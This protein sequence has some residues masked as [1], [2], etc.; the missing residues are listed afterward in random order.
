[1]K[2]PVLPILSAFV[3]SALLPLH[4]VQARTLDLAFLPPEVEPQNLCTPDGSTPQEED[5]TLEQG[6][7]E[8]SDKARLRFLRRDINNLQAA[9]PVR[10]FD[11]IQTLI[12]WQ[13]ELD[14]EFAGPSALLAKIS[15]YVDAGRLAELQQA[16]LLDQLRAISDRLNNQQGM[17]LAQ[18]YL[19]GIGVGKDEAFAR[20][21]MRDAAYGG[22][23]DALLSM[24]RMDLQGQ[25]VEG[26]D[27]PLDLTVTL[28][29]GGMLGRM[30]AAVCNHAERIAR[31]YLNGDLVTRNVEVAY[32]WYKFGADLGG[33]EAAWRIVEFHLD[34]DDIRK[35]EAE[36]LKYL[37]LAVERGIALEDGQTDRIKSAGNIDEATLREIL[38][39]N[40]SA[41][42]G[43]NRPSISPYLQL[44]VN[45]D[46]ETTADDSI[47][48]DYLREL[49]R[50]D[51]A[52]GW[53]FTR[54]ANEVLVR[55]GRWEAEPEAME[56]LEEAA[57]R[58]DP[59]GM[60]T[61]AKKLVR[62]RDDPVELNRAI[63]LLTEVATRF[64]E[65]T[66][67]QDLDTLYRCQANE[68]P[69]LAEANLWARNY[70]AAQHATV[71]VSDGDLISLDPFKKPEIL[72]Q[73]QT[74]ALQ[75]RPEALTDFVQRVQLDPLATDAA[76]R[77]WAARLNR[78]DKALEL[79]AEQEFALATNPVE[80]DL[81]L[82]LFRRVYLNNG[83]TTALDL[84]VAL[85]EDNARDPAVAKEIIDLLTRAGNRGEGSSIRLLW[86]LQSRSLSAQTVFEQFEDVI[87]ERGDFLALMFALPFVGNDKVDDYIDRAVSLMNCSIKDADELGDIYAVLLSPELTY[88]W[89]NVGLAIEGGHVLAKMGLSDEQMALFDT[90]ASPAAIEVQKRELADGNKTA[91]RNLFALMADAGL[92]S[93]DPEAA[94]GHL[95]ALLSGGN[96]ADEAWVLAAY[97]KAGPALRGMVANRID[98][99]DLFRKAAERGD[100]TAR[101]DYALILRDTATSVSDLQISAR[102]LKDA[103]EGGN[104]TAMTELGEVLAFGIGVPQDRRGSLVWL[105]QAERAGDPRARDLV[106]LLRLGMS[107]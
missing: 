20:A 49:T 41:D 27:A 53:V 87:E 63:N 50:F 25:P 40:Y 34:A 62:R 58:L 71:A 106:R 102:W 32:A 69:M 73:L 95:V 2:R 81:A 83:V 43:R 45:L 75:S 23:V 107:Q 48:I 56:L 13:A 28:A 65:M 39:F 15:L 61:L 57:R 35:D 26:W 88:H 92:P 99:R 18:Y 47:Y 11:F 82:E 9:D 64:G 46:G 14:P 36:M 33:A 79:F 12:D 76:H 68:A 94:V 10:W 55:R 86:R 77:F 21:L 85:T 4:A 101:L 24:A 8:L 80:R 105:E 22:N 38:G 3:L 5:L 54:L 51:T 30:N 19:N 7:V 42:T 44:T 16:G 29:F 6:I 17:A 60:Q 100:A 104:V 96:E 66:A 31:E 93:Y 90:G 89:R 59:E 37:R 78:S 74:H 72:A 98:I 1:M 84:A 52:P 67:M 97:R 70:R 103:S 91:H